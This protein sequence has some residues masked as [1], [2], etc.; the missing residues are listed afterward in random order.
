MSF[1]RIHSMSPIAHLGRGLVRRKLR[2]SA[3]PADAA[4]LLVPQRNFTPRPAGSGMMRLRR[5]VI[6]LGSL[7]KRLFFVE[8]K[9]GQGGF[10]AEEA[11]LAIVIQVFR[12]SKAERT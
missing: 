10:L 3:L 6:G 12:S 1:D 9:S 4:C 5:P 11:I 2:G 8:T 7:A